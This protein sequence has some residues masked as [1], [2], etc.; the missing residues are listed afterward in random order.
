M[1][2]AKVVKEMKFGMCQFACVGPAWLFPVQSARIAIN[3][4]THAISK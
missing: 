2:K 3:A 1:A 4:E